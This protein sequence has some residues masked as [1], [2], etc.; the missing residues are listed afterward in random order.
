[1]SAFIHIKFSQSSNTYNQFSLT[2]A[3]NH[4]QYTFCLL[5]VLRQPKVAHLY[6]YSSVHRL[7]FGF[8]IFFFHWRLLEL[9][10]HKVE[11][12]KI[13]EHENRMKANLNHTSTSFNQLLQHIFIT[14]KTFGSMTSDPKKIY[15]SLCAYTRK[16]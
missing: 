11:T 12:I 6:E 15:S 4:H 9:H 7:T 8:I 13:W 2:Q 1:M 3:L 14:N 16:L 10:V 5:K